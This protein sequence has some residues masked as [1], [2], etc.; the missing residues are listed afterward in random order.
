M[1]IMSPG[2]S[3]RGTKYSIVMVFIGFPGN[4]QIGQD[5]FPREA[6]ITS[7]QV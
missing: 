2:I 6:I 5:T 4:E 1:E 7:F 3:L